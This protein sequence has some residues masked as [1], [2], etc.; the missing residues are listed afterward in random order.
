M[1]RTLSRQICTS[2]AD[3]REF[4]LLSGDFNPL[5]VDPVAARRTQF[6]STVTHGIHLYLRALDALAAERL[7]DGLEPAALSATFNNPVLSGTPVTLRAS[8][9]GEGGKIRV[10]AEAAGR[11]AFSG[12]IELQPAT[13]SASPEDAEFAHTRPAE[14]DFPP[15]VT[16]GAVSLK[17]SRARLA[18][19]FP[20]LARLDSTAWIADLLA[21][22]QIVG[23]RCPGMDSIF[24]GF[25]LKRAT[26][27]GAAQSM[28]YEV[29]R[30]DP[31]FRL[32]RMQ[33]SGACLAGTI[34]TFFRPRPV[35]QRSMQ[36]VVAAVGTNQ[37]A[38]HRVLVIG[39]SRGLGELTAKIAAA[40]GAAVTI[41]YARG[42]DDAER[43]CAEIRAAN[44]SCTAHPFDVETTQAPPAWLTGER[45]THVYF[46]ASPPIAK[47]TGRWNQ[48]LFE[49][50]THV[51]VAAF[52]ALVEHASAAGADRNAAIHFLYPSSVFVAQ[53]EAGFAEYAVAKAAGE[54]LCDQL[55][56]RHGAQFSKP[57]LP[58]MR[59]DQTNALIDIGAEDPLA[60]ML[61]VVRKLHAA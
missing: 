11:P 9:E 42:K 21:S 51:Y 25:K 38:G 41:T 47:N 61:D 53:L 3:S 44:R 55:Q 12:V 34:E 15:V 37:C 32:A 48:A 60:V 18:A 10:A 58:R 28:R 40:C 2:L 23:M 4:G 36:D 1:T 31:R 8:V 30:T 56:G 17:L 33:V 7:L 46:F 27:S 22:T 59:T 13:A 20:S 29:N 43:V 35:A 45:F 14:V 6:G 50:F 26:T 5:H 39:G 54:A 19:L 24:S 57:R 49:R 16:S 52:A